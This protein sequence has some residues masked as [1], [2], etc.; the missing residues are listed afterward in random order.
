MKNNKYKILVLSD[1]NKTAS[2]TIKSSVSFAQMI[3]AKIELFHVK[4]FIDIV[5]RDNQLSA[6]RTLNEEHNTTKKAIEAL[7]NTI[8][9]D[10]NVNIGFSY[11]F[12]KIK[13]EIKK[14]I[15]SV[16]PDIIVLGQ[17]NSSPLQLIGDSVTRFIL[18]EF[19]VV[20]MIAANE[21]ALIPNKKMSLGVFNDSNKIF[22]SKFSQDLITHS[23]SP[24]KSFKII[25]SQTQS[26]NIALETEENKIE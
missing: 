1:L 18:K 11:S 7:V 17:R 12:G 3:D 23:E 13:E 24:L 5:D 22:E 9:S 15:E 21:N 25:N 19:K 2:T 26:N 4:K 6:I 20:I 8:S 14:Q 10:Y 16:K